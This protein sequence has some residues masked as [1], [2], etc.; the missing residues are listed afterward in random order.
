MI[1][2]DPIIHQFSSFL[3]IHSAVAITCIFFVFFYNV[4]SSISV[5]IQ[6]YLFSLKYPP[7]LNIQ[8]FFFRLIL[9]VSFRT[10]TRYHFPRWPSLW[11][12]RHPSLVLIWHNKSTSTNDCH[13]RFQCVFSPYCCEMHVNTQSHTLAYTYSHRYT[14]THQTKIKTFSLIF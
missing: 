10:Q 3:H 9:L 6:S 14:D 4:H 8:P 13:Y 7:T 11:I 5:F 2:L 12:F 1:W